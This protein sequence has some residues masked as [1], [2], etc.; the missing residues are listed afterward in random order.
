MIS[1]KIAGERLYLTTARGFKPNRALILLMA[2]VGGVSTGWAQM[3][4][5]S[6]TSVSPAGDFTYSVP[7]SVPPAT[8]GLQP[9]LALSYSSGAGDGLLGMGWQLSGE[10]RIAR[11]PQTLLQ[12][13]VRKAVNN[14]ISDRFCLDGQRLLA[15][16]SGVYGANGTEYRTELDG[17]TKVVSYS[18]TSGVPRY[19]SV[20]G[21]NGLVAEYGNTAD[22]KLTNN[23]G[24]TAVAWAINKSVDVMGNAIA[25]QYINSQAD[26]QLY[27]SSVSYGGNPQAGTTTAPYV[28][29]LTYTD[30]TK[31]IKQYSLG[32]VYTIAK[33]LTKVAVSQSGQTVPVWRYDLTYESAPSPATGRP[34]LSSMKQCMKDGSV[35]YPALELGWTGQAPTSY[36]GVAKTFPSGLDIFNG[37]TNLTVDLNGDGVTDILA[38]KGTQGWAL[39]AQPGG[40]FVATSKTLPGGLNLDDGVLTKTLSGDFN[41]DGLTDVFLARDTNYWILLSDGLGGFST[42]G[43]Q[44]LPGGMSYTSSGQVTTLD[45]SR[46]QW[47]VMDT[48]GDGLQDIVVLGPISDGSNSYI[49]SSPFVIRVFHVNSDQSLY[50]TY[51]DVSASI[52]AFLQN[53]TGVPSDVRYVSSMGGAD[54][55][56]DGRPEIFAS[57]ALGDF[58]KRQDGV[59]VFKLDGAGVASVS[60]ISFKGA[61]YPQA[62]ISVNG[63]PANQ[64]N[65]PPFSSASIIDFNGDGLPDLIDEQQGLGN[66][67]LLNNGSGFTAFS[68]PTQPS[69]STYNY[70]FRSNLLFPDD[71]STVMGDVNGDG[72]MDVLVLS[73]GPRVSQYINSGSGLFLAEVVGAPVAN[74]SISVVGGSLSGDF[75]GDGLIDVLVK[76]SAAGNYYAFMSGRERPDLLKQVKTGGVTH[77]ISYKATGQA[78]GNEYVA[79]TE[80][81]SYPLVKAR[82]DRAL[83]VKTQ[84]ASDGVVKQTYEYKFAGLLASVGP[85]GRGN[86]GFRWMQVRNVE[87]GLFSRSYFLQSYPLIG[88]VDIVGRGTSEANW[89]NLGLTTNLY[90]FRA[91]ASTDANYANPTAWCA[92]G[93]AACAGLTVKPGNRYVST[94]SDVLNKAWDWDDRAD[95]FIALPTTATAI[96]SMDNWGNA[97]QVKETVNKADGSYS[98]YSKTTDSVFAPAD[99]VNWRFGR[100]LKSTVTTTS[101]N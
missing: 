101:P 87:T 33:L 26:G 35:C 80:A 70:A 98:G 14:T 56:G 99:T 89:S 61:P 92:Q 65:A 64:Y 69:G 20:W 27:L 62:R 79:S 53:A 77:S 21:K 8:A 30:R 58:S 71:F 15:V 17:Y 11:C 39:I 86:L 45:Y 60:D 32:S 73:S 52:N 18:D 59:V 6:S 36:S 44:P 78:F 82:S 9:S 72:L 5:P 10:S 49:A 41:G 81:V 23:S 75:D 2:L 94:V 74:E 76:S 22:S 37:Y 55:D 66:P 13:G 88:S 7:I 93:D 51:T 34:R 83:V 4:M 85:R 47:L 91:F 38:M 12:D 48:D 25:Y 97:T 24:T 67:Y 90:K 46:Y 29:Q 57:M 96:T 43:A 42:K 68:A 31:P 50:V 100:V 84:M 1:H 54:F 95:V 40:G 19:F 63:V 16:G 28:V 3:F